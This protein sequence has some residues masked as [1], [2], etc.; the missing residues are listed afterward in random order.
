[1]SAHRIVILHVTRDGEGAARL[2]PQCGPGIMC[3]L[4]EQT[5]ETVHLSVGKI[6]PARTRSVCRDRF[7]SAA[8]GNTSSERRRKLP[9]SR[10]LKSLLPVASEGSMRRWRPRRLSPI[11]IDTG[12]DPINVVLGSEAIFNVPRRAPRTFEFVGIGLI[13]RAQSRTTRSFYG[14]SSFPL[15][16]PEPS[17][18]SGGV[19]VSTASNSV[20]TTTPGTGSSTMS[21]TTVSSVT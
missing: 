4:A 10:V 9:A 8:P 16:R 18:P 11:E 13:M 20:T 21:T 1:M 7:I 17:S 3:A 2:S 5:N 15:A 19:V 12:R 6:R 14:F